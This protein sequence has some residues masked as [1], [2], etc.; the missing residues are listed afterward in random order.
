MPKW[1]EA[2]RSR[3]WFPSKTAKLCRNHFC[4]NEFKKD[5][6]PSIFK[7]DEGNITEIDCDAVEYNSCLPLSSLWISHDLFTNPETD[8]NTETSKLKELVK[9]KDKKSGSSKNVLRQ[10]KTIK[11]LMATFDKQNYNLERTC[12]SFRQQ[13]QTYS[14]RTLARTLTPSHGSHN[15]ETLM[16]FVRNPGSQT[17]FP[18][19]IEV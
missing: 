11:G 17:T 3:N 6:V 4:N 7:D 10:A 18:P 19:M 9:K 2:V 5:A 14:C 16:E 12:R 13:F 15:I 1:S 8:E